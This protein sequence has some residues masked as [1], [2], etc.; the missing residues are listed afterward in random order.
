MGKLL[1]TILVVFFTSS[2]ITGQQ[3]TRIS[4]TVTDNQGSVLPGANIIIPALN[5]GAATNGNG[6]YQFTVPAKES[7]GQRVDMTVR[8]VGYKSQ[9]V[10]VILNGKNIE[11]NFSLEEDI[12][13]SEA[14]V[15]TG[16]AS[17]TSKS[18]AEVSVSRVNAAELTN[19]STF[20]TMSQ[21]VEGKIPGVQVTTS[22]GNAGGGYRFYVR[23]GGGLNGDEQPVIY[24]DGIRVGND[25]IQGTGVGGQGVSML[26]VLDPENISNIEVLKGPA[27]A[28]TYGTSG[29]NGVVLITT[30]SGASGHGS[31]SPLSV[32]YKYAY[33]LNTQSYKY[34]TSDFVSANDV[35]SIFRDGLIRQ[36]TI[37]ISGGSNLLRFYASFDDRNEEGNISNNGLNRK[38]L[39]ANLTSYTTQ[40][41]TIK[42]STEYSYNEIYRPQNDNNL[43]G[44]LGNTLINPVSYQY[45]TKDLIL[46]SVD[47]NTIESFTGGAQLTYTPMD[48]LEFYFNGGINHNNYS[49]NQVSPIN[50]YYNGM[51]GLETRENRQYTFDFNGRYS[52]DIITGLHATSIIGAQLFDRTSKGSWLYTEEFATNLITDIGA[53]AKVD[54]YGELFLNSREAGVFTE[55]N[56]SFNNQYYFTLGLREDYSSSIGTE[57]PSILYPKASLAVRLDKYNWF[58]SNLFTLFKLRAA[59]GENGQLPDAL[60]PIPFLW[61]ATTGGYGAGATINNI[62]NASIKP[63]R[64]KEIETGFE[65]EFLQDFSV[66]FTYYHQ[67]AF[68]SIVY[69]LESPSTGLTDSNVP[70]NIGGVK[71]WGIESLVKASLIR[72]TNYALDLS[73]I[74]NYQ[75]NEV[76]DLGGTEPIYD[77]FDVNVIKVG[78][79]KHEFYTWKVLGAKFNPDGTYA[80]VNA[81]QDRVDFGN[82]IPNN[83]GSFSIYFKF[84][85][86]FNLY[87]LAGWALNRKMFN[88]T[89]QFAAQFNNI[90]EYNT[91]QAQLGLTTA[92]PAVTRLIPGTP[93]YIN[94]ANKFAKMDYT[95]AGNYIEDAQYLKI[96]E[97][98]LSYSF[99]DLLPEFRYNYIKDITVGI[100]ALNV[101]T[102]TNYSGAD[103]EV[104]FDGS[105]SLSRGQDFLT[106]QHPRAY[107]LWVKV[108]L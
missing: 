83:S 96:R 63:E 108:A 93:E 46:K 65:A 72:S 87:A 16:I 40:N 28:A 76:T 86:N 91:L 38:D 6:K 62:G 78:L 11:Q 67:N 105:R 56:F 41:L 17:K 92:D 104:N 55:H 19:T 43:F 10:A 53:G 29:S 70:F 26:S 58:P 81:T 88:S 89:K 15:V 64:I 36:N 23:G 80:G 98:S 102:L 13:Q 8:Y 52:Y 30:K 97:I 71:N 42:V 90:P 60:A 77:G 14:V 49:D 103:P 79:P 31:A 101:F 74:W 69:M 24:V 61:G 18:V 107:N 32:N 2:V 57:A 75:K 37:D 99:K 82:P 34:K 22:S 33:G 48:K 73:F 1:F 51:R 94:A 5:L 47:K 45:F 20:Q 3:S 39:S 85:K 21:L 95:Y 9:T 100:S 25:E 12:F 35:N 54:Y 66:E 27:A 4:G 59:Y 7:K 106:L 50:P 44:Y 84:F 68:N